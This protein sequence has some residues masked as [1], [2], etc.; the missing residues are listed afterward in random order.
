MKE[1]II[2]CDYSCISNSAVK[3]SVLVELH[4]TDNSFIERL[5]VNDIVSYC[6]NEKLFEAIIENDDEILYNY[7]EKSGYIFNK[8]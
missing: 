5:E 8:A 6:D 7:L 1:L 4:N 3:N 2:A